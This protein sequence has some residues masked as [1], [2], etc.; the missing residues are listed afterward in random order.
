[1][2][3]TLAVVIVPV[4][5]QETSEPV[6]TQETLPDP[7]ITPDSP[8]YFFDTLGENIGLFFAFG[9][10]AKARKAVEI[11]GEKAAEAEAMA[12]KG[13]AAAAGIAVDRYGDM[14]STAAQNLAAAAQS[15]EGFDA[16]LAE[17][18]AKATSI[19]LSVLS[20]VLERVP[21]QAKGA[22]QNAME[23]GERGAGEAINALGQQEG[24][25]D[26]DQLREGVQQ[27]IDESRNLRG[28][29][30]GVGAP[31]GT[32]PGEGTR[33]SAPEG[34]GAPQGVGNQGGQQGGPP[35][36]IPGGRP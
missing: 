19:H 1:M 18:M 33:G 32:V 29:P 35:A 5:A 23:H 13:D 3:L 7:G 34:V 25:P 36:N 9:A 15:G 11:A 16:A 31:E 28:A 8:F 30:E 22:I 24:R 14:V 27:R 21:E 6:E 4:S 26:I 2:I 10:E 20:D 12:E 17:L